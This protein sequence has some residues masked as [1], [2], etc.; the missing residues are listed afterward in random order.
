MAT[1]ACTS[2]VKGPRFGGYPMLLMAGLLVVGGLAGCTG[3][4]GFKQPTEPPA[5]DMTGNWTG[6]IRVIPCN[7]AYTS[8][9][10]R[11]NAV[12]RIEFNLVQDDGDLSGAYRCAIGN[13]ICR[14]GNTTNYGTVQSGWVSGNQLSISVFL[15]GDLSN[16]RYT[17]NSETPN[18]ARGRYSCYQGGS[19]VEQGQWQLDRVAIEPSAAR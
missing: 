4:N 15:P 16:C 5:V 14:A 9:G 10:G 13:M 12:N 7:T 19:L 18:T 11:C 17:G 3:V 1:I 8:N 6:T 2:P